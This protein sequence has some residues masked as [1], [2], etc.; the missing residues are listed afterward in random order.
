[1][2]SRDIISMN[3]KLT[4]MKCIITVLGDK[5]WKWTA[6]Q[7]ETMRRND[8]SA[9]M[10]YSA[11]KYTVKKGWTVKVSRGTYKSTE[12]GRALLAVI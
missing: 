8:C 3:Q 4:L 12:K 6:L 10:F 5:Q 2:S 7:N 1:M 9:A 11:L